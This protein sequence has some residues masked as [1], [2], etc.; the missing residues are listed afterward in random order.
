MSRCEMFMS[1]SKNVALA[2]FLC[3]WSW[4]G[5]L[6]FSGYPLTLLFL[7]VS[8]FSRLDVVMDIMSN[9]IRILYN[10]NV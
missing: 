9:S 1:H 7:F 5:D 6:E 2:A 4:G 3:H 8:L 10:S